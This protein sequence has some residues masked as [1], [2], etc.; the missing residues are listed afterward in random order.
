VQRGL[1]VGIGHEGLW[2]PVIQYEE[3]CLQCRSFRTLIRGRLIHPWKTVEKRSLG[4]DNEYSQANEQVPHGSGVML[5][6]AVLTFPR[7]ERVL[8][9][10]C[11]VFVMR[12]QWTDFPVK[13]KALSVH[14]SESA[15]VDQDGAAMHRQVDQ[16]S[17]KIP[18]RPSQQVSTRLHPE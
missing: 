10:R 12:H 8:W 15:Q 7:T 17:V 5:A 2:R 1:A 11:V 16:P 18:P 6:Q 3:Q 13:N 9:L 4:L 14:G